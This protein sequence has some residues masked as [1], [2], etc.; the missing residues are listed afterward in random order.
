MVAVGREHVREGGGK[1]GR[2]FG[3]HGRLP[4]DAKVDGWALKEDGLCGIESLAAVQDDE[5]EKSSVDGR[6]VGEGGRDLGR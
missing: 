3:V 4:A 1:D 6:K 2:R 5:L